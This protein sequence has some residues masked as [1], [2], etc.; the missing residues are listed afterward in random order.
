MGDIDPKDEDWEPVEEIKK[1][2]EPATK[3]KSFDPVTVMKTLLK[4]SFECLVVVDWQN[5]LA[6]I[7]LHYINLFHISNSISTTLLYF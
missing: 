1:D 3:M 4:K 2:D 7:S 6:W 5:G